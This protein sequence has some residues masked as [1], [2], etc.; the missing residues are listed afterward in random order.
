MQTYNSHDILNR[1]D[2]WNDIIIYHK[3]RKYYTYWQKLLRSILKQ[4]GY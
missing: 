4:S 3:N 1:K 2:E